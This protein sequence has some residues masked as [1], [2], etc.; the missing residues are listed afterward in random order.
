M[1]FLCIFVRLA[2]MS[3]LYFFAMLMFLTNLEFCLVTWD[4]FSW[5]HLC[6]QWPFFFFLQPDSE[7][8]NA[9]IKLEEYFEELLNGIYRD[10][11]FPKMQQ[12]QQQQQK[13]DL[14]EESE[15][16]E[17]DIVQPRKKRKL[18]DR[19]FFRWTSF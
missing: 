10:K 8:A 19:M 12:Q 2:E 15:D 4:H 6:D 13:E 18:D 5:N 17:D 1:Y 3:H 7:V 9:G 14:Q 16:S 11:M